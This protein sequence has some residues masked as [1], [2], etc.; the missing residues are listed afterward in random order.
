RAFLFKKKKKGPQWCRIVMDNSTESWIKLLPKENLNTL[1]ISGVKWKEFGFKSYKNLFFPN[2]D[3]CEQETVEKFDL[4][5]AE[6]VFEHLNFP[7]RAGRNIYS[8]LNR[9]GYF[10][11]T[12]PFLI[13]IHKHPTDSTRWTPDGLR[14]FLHECGF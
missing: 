13:K 1:E 3:I 14:Y 4:I 2:F 9:E 10:L 12:T 8:M 11:I 6:Q 7:Y 5:I